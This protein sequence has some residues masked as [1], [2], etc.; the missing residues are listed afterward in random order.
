MGFFLW[1]NKRLSFHSSKTAFVLNIN[2][3][4]H[5]NCYYV[6]IPSGISLKVDQQL[7]ADLV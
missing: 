7:S 2:L 4:V 5:S 3:H 6:I 1:G